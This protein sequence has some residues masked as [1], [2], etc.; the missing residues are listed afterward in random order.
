MQ[1][2]NLK[3]LLGFAAVFLAGWRLLL[4]D[5]GNET[6]VEFVSLIWFYAA[7]GMATLVLLLA[8]WPM[9]QI[10]KQTEESG[11][12]ITIVLSVG[13]RIILPMAVGFGISQAFAWWIFYSGRWYYP[14]ADDVLALAAFGCSISAARRATVSDW[15]SSEGD[16]VK[17][18]ILYVGSA[19]RVLSGR[20]VFMRRIYCD[21]ERLRDGPIYAGTR[22]HGSGS[23]SH[24]RN[25]CDCAGCATAAVGIIEAWLPST[26]TSIDTL[27]P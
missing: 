27:T 1:T 25:L 26:I 15:A 24:C 12:S 6:L 21:D 22:R 11:L 13:W 5:A 4:W 17:S 20:P 3:H 9:I 7:I 23:D 14:Q 16:H 18:K 2:A 19:N 8:V 10:I